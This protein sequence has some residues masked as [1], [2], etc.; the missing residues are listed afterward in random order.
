[1]SAE[2]LAGPVGRRVD[3][4]VVDDDR[5]AVPAEDARPLH[6]VRPE[7]DRLAERP[8]GVLRLLLGGATVGDDPRPGSRP[9]PRTGRAPDHVLMAPPVSP[10]TSARWK[11]TNSTSSG[12]TEATATADTRCHWTSPYSPTKP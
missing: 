3:P 6:H 5:V 10:L 11:T 8:E 1:M 2:T 4:E 7:L 9:R 12:I